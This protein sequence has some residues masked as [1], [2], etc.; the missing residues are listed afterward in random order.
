L[1]HGYTSTSIRKVLARARTSNVY[2]KEF[3]PLTDE[4]F[5]KPPE[6]VDKNTAGA[7][8]PT[9]EEKADSEW[10]LKADLSKSPSMRQGRD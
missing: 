8:E 4:G 6:P 1:R 9:E 3:R 10:P 2:N 7:E 5:L